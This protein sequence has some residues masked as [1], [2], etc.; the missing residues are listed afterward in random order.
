MSTLARKLLIAGNWKMNLNSS[1]LQ[2][3]DSIV[4]QVGTQWKSQSAMSYLYFFRVGFSKSGQFKHF[5]GQNMHHE[6]QVPIRV[7]FQQRCFA[8][9]L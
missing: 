2:I 1:R 5:L 8:I 3:A 7:K 4:N 6:I 9:Y